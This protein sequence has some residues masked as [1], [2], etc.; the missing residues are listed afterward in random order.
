MSD[1]PSGLWVFDFAPPSV[2]AATPTPDGRVRLGAAR[3]NPAS[4]SVRVAFAL[5]SVARVRMDVYDVRGRRVQTLV[6]ATLGAGAHE[7]FWNGRDRDGLETPSGVYFVR[8]EAL[9]EVHRAR[10]VRVR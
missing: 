5:P 4:G 2:T 1:R 10:V 7:A 6:D 8:L 9:G 3:P